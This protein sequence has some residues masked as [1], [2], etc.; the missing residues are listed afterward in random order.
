[1]DH[2]IY[3]LGLNLLAVAVMMIIGWI[4]SLVTKNVTVVDSLW[5]IGFVLIAWITFGLADGYTG[6]K[7]LLAVLTTLW[8][9]R[10]TAYLSW[11]NAGK[12]EDPRYGAWRARYGRRF[13]IVSLFN[14]FLVQALFMWAIALSLQFGQIPAEPARLTVFDVLGALLWMVGFGFESLGDWQLAHFKSDPG[15]KGKVMDRGLWAYSRHPNYFGE[16]LIWWGIFLITLAVPG[17]GWTV[18]SPILISIVLIKITGVALTEKT[19]LER[20]PEYR[21]YIERTPTLFP[22]FPK[23]EKNK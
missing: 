19:I 13:W 7:L 23:K 20:R 4:I 10:L 12:G 17:G 3:I 15:N 22:W 1:M 6:R 18:I 16:M 21:D 11:R 14:V 5:G 8:G 9:L 2:V